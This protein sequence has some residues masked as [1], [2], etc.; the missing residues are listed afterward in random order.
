[1]KAA[2]VIAAKFIEAIKTTQVLPWTKQFVSLAPCNA[3]NKKLYRGL[4]I[5][6]CL[7]FGKDNE[8]LTFHQAKEAGGTVK[9]GAKGIP[10]CFWSRV[11][12]KDAAGN[13]APNSKPFWFLRYY[14]V[15]SLSDIEG[16]KVARRELP[17]KTHTP[18]QL[19]EMIRAA[20]G[21][22]VE[23]SH[24]ASSGSYSPALHKI[25]MPNPEQFKTSAN[26]YK[27]LFHEITHSL[28]KST[29]VALDCNFFSE[30]YGKEELVAELGAN[31][32]L[33]HCGIDVAGLF[34]N[35]QAYFQSWLKNLEGDPTMLISAASQAQKRFDFIL[36]KLN[37]SANIAVEG[38]ADR[39]IVLTA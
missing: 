21:C 37:P 2:E 17:N 23:H 3:L 30:S 20:A 26:Y 19:A 1:M 32:F 6:S 16:A 31:L 33:Q 22:P 36:A 27:T 35:S 24:A 39:G 4:N 34:D 7:Y 5:F 18:D 10:I 29:G 15:F 25:T 28:A 12:K 8:F 14:T 11:Q 38:D 9:K 13:P